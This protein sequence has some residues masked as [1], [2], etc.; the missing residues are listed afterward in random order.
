MEIK[1]DDLTTEKSNPKTT[2]ID[3]MNT[4]EM[5]YVINSEDKTVAYAVEKEIPNIARAVDLITAKLKEGGRLIYVGAGTSGRL[6]IIDASECP[7]T[8]GTEPGTVYAMIAG[9]DTALRNAVEGAE[10]SYES[11]EADI[12]NINIS[13]KDVV[14]GISASGSARYVIGALTEAKKKGAAAIAVCNSNPCP[15]LEIADIG[16]SPIVG[17]EVIMGSTRMKAGTSQKMV[18]NMLTTASMIKLGKVYKNLMVD[19]VLSNKKLKNRMKRIIMLA[20]DKN[21]SE[22]EEYISNHMG[23][24]MK[25]II[26]SLLTGYGIDEAVKLL[27]E[28]GGY[29]R[30]AIEA[31]QNL[32]NCV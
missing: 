3:I 20:T 30:K 28:N 9:G 19:M 27:K 29:V 5:L 4:E 24:N 17:P 23:A 18:L 15:V 16:I 31:A 11:G 12:L 6:G 32:H 22:V 2:D 7:P 25:E 26:V 10:D 21:Q 1:Y 8:F 14:V 13:E